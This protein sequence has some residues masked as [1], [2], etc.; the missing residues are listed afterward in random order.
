[1]TVKLAAARSDV[2]AA[3]RKARWALSVAEL[4]GITGQPPAGVRGA[5]ATLDAEGALLV[6]R[7]RQGGKRY[8]WN[9]YAA[10]GREL[11]A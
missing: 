10:G 7:N 2:E 1:M 8:S 6:S 11:G 3:L 4:A 5:V 9:R